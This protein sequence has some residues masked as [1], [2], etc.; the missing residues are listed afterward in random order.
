MIHYKGYSV[1]FTDDC[2]ENKGG[3]YCQ[4]YSDADYNC[5]IDYFCIHPEDFTNDNDVER[6]AREYID[7][8]LLKNADLKQLAT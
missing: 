2:D 3:Y 1:T 6:L 4:V 7:A 5:E 8:L